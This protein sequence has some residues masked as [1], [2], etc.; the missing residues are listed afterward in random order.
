MP[1]S[2]IGTGSVHPSRHNVCCLALVVLANTLHYVVQIADCFS[3]VGSLRGRVRGYT[4][5]STLPLRV[6]CAAYRDVDA[7][8]LLRTVAACTWRRT[9]LSMWRCYV[10][11]AQMRRVVLH[12]LQSRGSGAR[13]RN[14]NVADLASRSQTAVCWAP[15]LPLMCSLSS[16][17]CLTRLRP[18]DCC[19]LG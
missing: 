16:C 11:L 10:G 5:D 6:C 4:V 13:C 14:G 9:E 15:R 12:T 8:K 3:I 1:T 17:H 7:V 19:N 2:A 18:Y